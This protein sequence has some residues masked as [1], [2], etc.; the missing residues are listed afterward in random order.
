MESKHTKGEWMLPHFA[1][2][3]QKEDSCQCGYVLNE[4]YC[5][6]IA[7]VHFSKNKDVENGD[8]PLKEEAIANAKL[9][10]AA[11]ELLEACNR[12]ILLVDLWAPTYSTEEIS[13]CHIGE[14]AALANLRSELEKAI[15]KA[16]K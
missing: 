14:L 13:E 9:I 4:Q 11:P 15:E 3:D 10:T 1:T 7:T 12:A 16:T 2:A 8:N 5:G 6:A